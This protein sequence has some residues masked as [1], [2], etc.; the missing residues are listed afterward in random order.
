MSRIIVLVSLAIGAIAD[1]RMSVGI[2]TRGGGNNA[3]PKA[4]F[5]LQ[6]SAD[7]KITAH[8]ISPEQNY[9]PRERSMHIDYDYINKRAR[10]HIAPGAEAEKTYI[11]RYDLE[12]EYMIR[13]PP[14]DDCK[15]SFLGE[16]MPYPDVSSA[17]FLGEA[18]LGSVDVNHF[19]VEEYE[20][21]IHLYFDKAKGAPLMLTQGSFK[22]EVFTPLMTYE[23]S[24]V[25]L[26]EP[27][28]ELFEVPAPFSH[29]TCDRLAGG[30]PYLHV[31]HYFVRF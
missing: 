15:R 12:K 2:D 11:R 31:F 25:V 5:P 6:I 28:E 22:N 3:E 7:I 8:L 20:T 19:V 30:F 14:I 24:N 29:A 16:T 9:P 26:E 21:L 1:A 10:A 13:D 23:Y 17:K 27:N 18:R 4:R